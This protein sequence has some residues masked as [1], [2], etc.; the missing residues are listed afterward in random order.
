MYGDRWYWVVATANGRTVLLPPAKETENEAR[1]YARKMITDGIYE[2]WS[3]DTANVKLATQ[4]YRFVKLRQ[5]G[6]VGVAIS[7]MKH[8]VEVRNPEEELDK[9][10]NEY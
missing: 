7:R 1:D 2:I 4:K 9:R 5:T 3:T 6:N 8:T 10:L